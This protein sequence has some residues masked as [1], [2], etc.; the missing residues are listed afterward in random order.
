[1]HTTSEHTHTA[2]TTLDGTGSDRCATL[3]LLFSLPGDDTPRIFTCQPAS[4]SS[5]ST[6]SHCSNPSSN[7]MWTNNQKTMTK[8]KMLRIFLS[9]ALH[10]SNHRNS[11]NTFRCFFSRFPVSLAPTTNNNNYLANITQTFVQQNATHTQWTRSTGRT[12]FRDD[13]TTPDCVGK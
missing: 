2:L 8:K 7:Q 5:F 13:R 9:R 10:P 12:K 6:L 11:I 3:E 4:A 1:M